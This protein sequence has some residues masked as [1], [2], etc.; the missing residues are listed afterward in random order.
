[1]DDATD[2]E[3]ASAFMGWDILSAISSLSSMGSVGAL[4]SGSEN[5][6]GIAIQLVS[7]IGFWSTVA[8]DSSGILSKGNENDE[9]IS[10]MLPV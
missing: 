4:S 8:V 2:K 5:H 10:I 7:W 9:G 3:S 1:M 6:K